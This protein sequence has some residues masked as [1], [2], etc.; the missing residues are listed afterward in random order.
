MTVV[1]KVGPTLAVPNSSPCQ[2]GSAGAK[3]G[4]LI[5]GINYSPEPI[6]VGRYTG[7]LGSF[8]I[9]QGVGVDVV[10]AI[11]HY[12]GWRVRG[13]YSNR[14]KS[15]ALDGVQ[16]VRCPLFLKKEMKGIWRLLAPLS[17][18]ITSAPVAI[19]KIFSLRPAAILCVEPTLFSAPIALLCAKLIGA[20]TILH[21][22]DLE[23][24]A[25]FAVG[26]LR[27]GICEKVAWFSERLI[28]KSFDSVVTISSR[29]RDRLH[30][31]GVRKDRLHLVRNWV[32][33]KHIK[34]LGGRSRFRD[35]LGLADN[36]FVV[37]YSGNI[38]PKQA[39]HLILE[40]ALLLTSRKDI[41]FVIAGEGPEKQSLMEAYRHLSNVRFIPL[42]PEE[43]LCE[44]LNF[45]DVHVLPQLAGTADLVLPSK[46][47]G[48]LA[49]GKPC[50]V[51]ADTGTELYEFLADAALLSPAGNTSALCEA[52][53]SASVGKASGDTH[54][55]FQ[56]VSSLDAAKNLHALY[57]ILI[58]APLDRDA[59]QADS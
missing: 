7:E 24:D 13:G 22:Q 14:Y 57:N 51:M 30:E 1:Q 32:D 25:A 16:I 23:I 6:G 10:T 2:R 12:P 33:T 17:F 26:H 31:K 20:R 35:E 53:I 3:F 43:R 50:I 39:L 52:I 41:V 58:D 49:S 59:A 45:A 27:C 56:A 4:V 15:E 34:P 9:S 54:R 44:L 37:L 55:R 29:M 28:L 38:G 48:M 36:D 19:W 21:V 40:A 5:Y 47:G 8:L 18:A 11:P 42:Q 46:L